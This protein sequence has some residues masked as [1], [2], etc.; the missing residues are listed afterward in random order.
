MIRPKTLFK[1]GSHIAYIHTSLRGKILIGDESYGG[2]HYIT[3]PSSEKYSL[4]RSLVRDQKTKYKP[5]SFLI[6]S[7][8]ILSL[9]EKKF[10]GSNTNPYVEILEFLNDQKIKFS[11]DYWPNR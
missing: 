5:L 10:G 1:E 2:D 9:F 7:F 11:S 6:P 3:I 8:Q 4:L